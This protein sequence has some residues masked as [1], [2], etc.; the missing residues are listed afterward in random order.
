MTSPQENKDSIGKDLVVYFCLL[1]LAGVQFI[2]A[3]QNLDPAQMFARMLA[4]ACVEA[5]LAAL[6]F[7]HLWQEKRGFLIFVSI[8][9]IFVFLSIQ[10]G[11]TDSFRMVM[12]APFSKY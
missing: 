10:F 5:G 8:F 6:F 7:M 2:I 12:G 4:V 1:A 3:Y 9:V 11:W